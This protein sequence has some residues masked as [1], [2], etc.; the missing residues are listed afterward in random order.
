MGVQWI[1]SCNDVRV[2]LAGS[3]LKRDKITFTHGSTMNIYFLWNRFLS[4]RW[5]DLTWGNSLFSTV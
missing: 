2:N 5:G 1:Y 4:F 3:S